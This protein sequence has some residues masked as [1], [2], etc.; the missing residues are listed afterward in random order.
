MHCGFFLQTVVVVLLV[1]GSLALAQGQ[2]KKSDE[3]TITRSEFDDQ[4]DGTFSWVSELSDGSKQEQSGKLKQIG[5]EQGIA[6]TGSYSYY[7]PEGE[8]R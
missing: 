4:G 1:V 5:E 3:V 6:L 7:S 2:Q 8:T